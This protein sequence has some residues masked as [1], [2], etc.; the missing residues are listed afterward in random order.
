MRFSCST[1]WCACTVLGSF[2]EEHAGALKIP[3]DRVVVKA[4]PLE[5]IIASKKAAN[6]EKDKLVLPVLE[7]AAAAI[8]VVEEEDS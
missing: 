8:R 5:R 1:S 2:E 4:L 7:D 6:R 3:M